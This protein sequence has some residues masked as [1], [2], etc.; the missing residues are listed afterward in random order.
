M[1][2]KHGEPWLLWPNTVSYGINKGDINRT[3]EGDTDFTMSMRIKVLSKTP[4][5]RTI[6]SKLPNYMGLDVEN[7][8]NN[9]LFICN[10]DE[11]GE[12]NAEYLFIPNELGWDWNFI[13]IRYNNKINY[14]DILINDVVV[15]EKQLKPNQRISS[16]DQSHV[17]FG[18][19]NFPHNGF[20]LNYCEYEIDHLLIS[21]NYLSYNVLSE[22]YETKEVGNNNVIGLYDFTEKTDYKI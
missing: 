6:F 12:R 7:D 20:N 9:L 15:F 19:G 5:K 13:T 11:D 8:N 1:I 21:K 18:S 22:I 4:S 3:L 17:I 16:D 2:I 10:F 14:I